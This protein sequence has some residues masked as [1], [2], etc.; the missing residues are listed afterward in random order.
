MIAYKITNTVNGKSYIGITRG[1]LAKRWREHRCA[2][3][4]GNDKPLYRAIRKYGEHSFELSVL[5]EA[6]SMKELQMVERGLIAQYGT[7]KLGGRGYNMTDGGEGI[8][9]V[10]RARG[11]CSGLS[12]LNEDIIAFI[13]DPEKA[14][15]P[16]AQIV[17]MVE[18]HFGKRFNIDTL[19]CG[20]N[21]KQ[22]RHLNDRFP[23]IK[24][25]KGA[26]QRK[27]SDLKR[28]VLRQV[29]DANRAA[30]VA[31]SAE[32]SR[33]RRAKHAKL[34]F[35]TVK[36]IFYAD[37]SL[38]SVAKQYGLS[39]KMVILIRQQKTYVYWTKEFHRA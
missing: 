8:N 4:S 23:P 11:E 29:L 18:S 26:R 2:A 25:V 24:A 27:M 30:A 1:S 16:N 35:D 37:G 9:Y 3:N 22:W 7:Y 21:G 6:T 33:G 36:D 39:K 5:Y 14:H 34:D 38:N 28:A 12:V 10:N 13:R 15:I 31:R 32:L 19:K 20:R 17:D